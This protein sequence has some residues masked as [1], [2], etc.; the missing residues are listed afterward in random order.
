MS[1]VLPGVR[2]CLPEPSVTVLPVHPSLRNKY[3]VQ[4]QKC[5]GGHTLA[6]RSTIVHTGAGCPCPLSSDVE[7]KEIMQRCR[8]PEMVPVTCVCF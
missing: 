6:Q 7:P 3:Q 4:T 5:F 8:W 1:L 2:A